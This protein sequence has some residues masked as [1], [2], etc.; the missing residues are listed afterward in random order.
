M[1]GINYYARLQ[2]A[3]DF[4]EAN[5]GNPISLSDVSKVAFS[6]LSYFHRVFYFMTGLTVKEYIRRRRLAM[7]AY[8]LHCTKLAV[9]EIALSAGYE[10]PESFARAFKKYFAVGPRAFRQTNQEHKL[11]E[12][13]NIFK[14][15]TVEQPPLDFKLDLEYVL[16]KETN[17]QGL[18]IHTTLDGGQQAIDICKFAGEVMANRKLEQYFDLKTTPVFGVYT[19]M[20][21]ES[22]FDYTI[23]CLE[24]N[25]AESVKQLVSHIIPTSQYA[26]FTLNRMD[27]I[28]EAWHYIYGCWFPQ[29]NQYRAPGFD[30]EIY[31][32]DSVAIYIPMHTTP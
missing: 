31:Y 19:N 17:I 7:A 15:Y 8:Q 1:F 3:V 13:I 18:Q 30:F 16:Y 2:K 32:P 12:K 5:L 20:T 24:N 21:D 4:I 25:N 29:V 10:T 27:R 14:K 6:S 26:K 23:G 11:F 22:E 9:T 28:K